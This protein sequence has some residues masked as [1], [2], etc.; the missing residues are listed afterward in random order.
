MW[1]LFILIFLLLQSCDSGFQAINHRVETLMAQATESLGSETVLPRSV[2]WGALPTSSPE[3]PLPKTNNP[4]VDDLSLVSSV[5]VDSEMIGRKLDESVVEF[6]KHGTLITL[7]KSLLWATQNAQEYRF[8]EYDYLST[9]LSLLSELHLWGPRFFESVV[10][11]TDAA[12]TDGFY[13]TS[14]TVVH[15]FELGSRAMRAN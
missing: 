9:T 8:A 11:T 13:D 6:E 12:S 3:N 4:S 7:D 2:I 1:R 14:M 10:V 5:G 15:D